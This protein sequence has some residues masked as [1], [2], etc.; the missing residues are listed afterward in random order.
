M[1]DWKEITDMEITVQ[2]LQKLSSD[3]YIIR[4]IHV[5]FIILNSF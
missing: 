2:P 5:I 1:S 3:Q 4:I